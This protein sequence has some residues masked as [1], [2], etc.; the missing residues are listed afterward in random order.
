MKSLFIAI[1]ILIWAPLGQAGSCSGPS[2]SAVDGTNG[3]QIASGICRVYGDNGVCYDITSLLGV[4]LQQEQIV[5][6][7]MFRG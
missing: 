7:K 3:C 6:A 1:F 5:Q 2:C 4:Q